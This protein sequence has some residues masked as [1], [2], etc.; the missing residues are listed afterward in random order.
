M[1]SKTGSA[2][3]F[4][5]LSLAIAVAM[6]SLANLARE[7]LPNLRTLLLMS[8]ASEAAASAGAVGQN[9]ELD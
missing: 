1:S 3:V 7:R 6:S 4:V 9:P 5:A 8:V 2:T